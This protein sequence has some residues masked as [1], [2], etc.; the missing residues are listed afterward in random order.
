MKAS[1]VMKKGLPY[2]FLDEMGDNDIRYKNFAGDP[3]RSGCKKSNQHQFTVK[4]P[5]E[6]VP[7]M[8]DNG[9]PVDE[10]TANDDAGIYIRYNLYVVMDFRFMDRFPCK[11]YYAVDGGEYRDIPEDQLGQLD[12][13]DF[14]GV[15][16]MIRMSTNANSGKT[17]LYLHKGLFD[18]E[19]DEIDAIFNERKHHCGDSYDKLSR[20]AA[21]T[22]EEEIPFN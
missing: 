15:K 16:L 7:W 6:L 12:S 22:D 19:A 17:T 4:V 13:V 3:A 18:S 2:L 20:E 11:V 21:E 5:E 1:I 14:T 8:R 10:R 9:V